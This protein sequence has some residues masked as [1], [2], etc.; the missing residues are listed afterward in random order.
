M[1]EYTWDEYYEK[2]FDWSESTQIRYLTALTG[3]GD[4]DEVLEVA[5]GFMDITACTKFVKAALDYGVKF[6][7]EQVLELVLFVDQPL[8]ERMAEATEPDFTKEQ[9][10]ELY[11]SVDNAVLQRL[12]QKSGVDI[13]QDDEP[14]END[15]EDLSQEDEEDW[16]EVFD[17]EP[18]K[19]IGFFAQLMA[20]L[21]IAGALEE[22]NSPKAHSGRCSGDCA[23]CPPHYG[24]RYGRW[25][26]GHNH[27]RGCEFGGNKG[28]GT[29]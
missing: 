23:H 13:F 12:S 27:Q 15:E 6:T 9:L 19:R 11:L 29:P 25:Y 2:S 24:Y 18:P 26:Y 22:R 21:G 16:E 8:L 17:T 7:P 20:M 4:P 28:D 10:E 1:R 3:F 14:E 5:Q